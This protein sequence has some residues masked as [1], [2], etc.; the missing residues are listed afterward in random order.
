MLLCSS[1]SQLPGWT[2][3]ARVAVCLAGCGLGRCCLKP[4]GAMDTV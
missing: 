4:E 1:C 3:A 2:Y